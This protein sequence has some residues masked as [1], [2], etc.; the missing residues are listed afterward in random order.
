MDNSPVERVT[1]KAIQETF[2]HLGVCPCFTRA[3]RFEYTDL[4]DPSLHNRHILCYYLKVK[5]NI[6]FSKDN[7]QHCYCVT[8]DEEIRNEVQKVRMKYQKTVISESDQD[9]F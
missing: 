7:K 9:T 8:T 3:T 1:Y 5:L 2:C 4:F 6:S